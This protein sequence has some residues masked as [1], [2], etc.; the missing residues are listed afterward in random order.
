MKKKSGITALLQY[1]LFR[2][3]AFCLQIFAID[4]TLRIASVWARG[5]RILMPRHYRRAIEHL[6]AAYGDTL[7][8][9]ELADLADRCLV[10]WTMFAI[11]LICAPR[12]IHRWSWHRTI[13]LVNFQETLRYLL[14][15]QSA[16]LVTGHFGNWELIGHLLACVGFDVAAVMRPLDNVYLND[17]LVKTRARHGLKLIDKAGAAAEAEQMLHHGTLLGFIAD[18]DAGR[19]GVFVDFFGRPAST[20]KSIALLA[21]QTQVPII[22]GYAQRVGRRFRYQVG[23]QR[24]I[25]PKDWQGCDDPLRWITQTYMSAIEAAARREPTQ[26][27]WMHRRWKTQPKVSRQVSAISHQLSAVS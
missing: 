6:R 20:Y 25:W 3:V 10:H 12:L 4:T 13:E 19:K 17:F 23:V 22:V 15:G 11:E 7:S 2:M 9:R 24:I 5:W 18:Q 14:T 26:Y 8:Q 21:M 16:I 1:G 27:L